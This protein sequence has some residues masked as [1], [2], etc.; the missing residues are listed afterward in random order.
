M[1]R[2]QSP[3]SG[4]HRMRFVLL[5]FVVAV[6]INYVWEMA[7]MPLYQ[8]MPFDS[9]RSW[10][11]CFRASLGDGIIVLIIWAMGA[12]AF[13]RIGWY[14]PLRLL[15][16]AVMLLLGAVIAVA[17]EVHALSTDRWAYS[18]LMPIV[19]LVEVGAS[20]F[21]QLLLLP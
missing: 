4:Q 21:V 8:N 9:L 14:R 16:T 18:E 5:L 2:G 10:L 15:N 20:P 3:L 7:Q 17:I 13:R 19:P 6:G 11:L 12:A 1:S